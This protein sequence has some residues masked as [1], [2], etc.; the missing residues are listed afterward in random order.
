VEE[1]KSRIVVHTI[2]PVFESNSKILILGTMPSVKSREHGFFYMHPQNIFWRILSDVLS[3]EFPSSIEDKKRL[4]LENRIAL[5]D[6]LKSCE[7]KGSSDSSIKKAV[8]NDIPGLL[9][10]TDIQAV[11][12]TGRTATSLFRKYFSKTVGMES[13]YLP[14]TS[15]ANNTISYEEKLGQWK[16][17]LLYLYGLPIFLLLIS[18]LL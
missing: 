12:T 17:I 7:I 13:I 5:W 18:W 6:V 3:S 9:K 15:P 10:K 14:S 16:K 8:P 2:D 1:K 11:F 4:L